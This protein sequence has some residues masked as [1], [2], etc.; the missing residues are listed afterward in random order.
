MNKAYSILRDYGLAQDAV[1]EAFIRVFK[2]MHKIDDPDSGKTAAFLVM[3][4]RNVSLT[5]LQKRKKYVLD[6]M[7]GYEAVDGYDIEEEFQA[8][9]AAHELMRLIDGLKDELRTPFLLKYAY[10]YSMK[11]IAKMLK[12]TENN[13]TVRIHR[14]RKKLAELYGKGCGHESR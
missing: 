11:E 3:I 2:N 9:Q 1:S 10:D 7:S 6:D 5:M 14:A 12:I 13:A 4:V 8:G